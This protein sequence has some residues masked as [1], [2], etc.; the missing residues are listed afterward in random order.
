M[1]TITFT[2][3][4][5]AS[6][7]STWAKEQVVNG[8]GKIVRVNMDDIRSML[9]LPYS[10]YAEE[11]ALRV[12][13][14]AILSAVKSGRDVIVDNTHIEKKMP[15]RIKKLFDGDVIF[16]IKDFT[17]VPLGHCLER[18]QQRVGSA[19]V[20]ADVIRRMHARLQKV[21][22]TEDWL[23]DVKLSPKLIHDP[24]IHQWAVVFDIDGTL[25]KHVSRSPYDYSRVLTD[26]LFYE[27]A[28]L[29]WT[30]KE[31]GYTVLIM[32]GRPGSVQIRKDTEQWLRER[33]VYFDAL[34]MRG[35]NYA[36]P[37]DDKRNDSDVKQEMVDQHIRGKYNVRLWFDDRDRVV[38]RLRKLGIKVAQVADG[39]F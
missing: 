30:F 17:D 4:L 5:P 26:E 11:L 1:Q 15:T 10:V 22:I 16:K 13:D 9:G 27:I 24:S 36:N 25:A 3:G 21:S 6:G 19:H 23:N 20:G 18:D 12:Q 14:Q 33:G 28:E 32:S 2:R 38:R 8:N 34:H 29:T 35:D 7:K 39:D 31:E 37:E